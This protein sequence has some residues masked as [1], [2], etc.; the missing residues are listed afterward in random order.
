MEKILIKK[1]PF[2]QKIKRYFS[3]SLIAWMPVFA[4]QAQCPA[5]NVPYTE[6]FESSITPAM[7][8][9]ITR[10]NASQEN[11]RQWNTSYL[12][13]VSNSKGANIFRMVKN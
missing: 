13:K 9:C 12:V 7:P 10:E 1:W 5:V 3:I 2:R 6:D 8:A 11:T 4:A